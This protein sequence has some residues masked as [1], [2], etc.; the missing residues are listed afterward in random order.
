M[1][2]LAFTDFHG[3]AG[4]YEKAKQVIALQ[5]PDFVIVA[6]DVINHDFER[7]KDFLSELGNA[8]RPVYFVPGNMDNTELGSWTGDRNVHGLHGRCKYWED[9]ALLGL[10]GSPH[11]A[12][13]T[14]FEY[15]ER[16]A[17]ELL[18]KAVSDFHGDK[19]I[20]ISHC[21]PMDTEVDRVSGGAHIGSSAVRGFVEKVRP[22][23]VVSG[24]VH[25]AQGV[26]KIESCTVVN[27]GPARYGDYARIVV[28]TEVEVSFQKLK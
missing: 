18:E 23:L 21:P 11:G 12:F 2:I 14:V 27:T 17:T 16:E 25:E 6:G 7:A 26:D 20:L 22:I 5:E 19:L 13:R 15:S 10:G 4:A 1:N 28:G 9:V 24:H 8:G 3:N